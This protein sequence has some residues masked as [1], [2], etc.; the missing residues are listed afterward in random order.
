M[1]WHGRFGCL[2]GLPLQGGLQPRLRPRRLH[3]PR[4]EGFEPVGVQE[5]EHLHLLSWCYV[6][7]MMS[8]CCLGV[9]CRCAVVVLC[10]NIIVFFMNFIEFHVIIWIYTCS[11]IFI[12]IPL[13]THEIHWISFS[14]IEFQWI[15]IN[16]IEFRWICLHFTK[17]H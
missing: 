16:S 11:M 12:Q 8:W 10:H 4:A 15:S 3:P 13:N 7:F 9:M 2:P 5:R 1:G 14:F 17:F 6:S